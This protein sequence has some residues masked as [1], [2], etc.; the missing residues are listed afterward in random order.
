MDNSPG[1]DH[2]YRLGWAALELAP[3]IDPEGKLTGNSHVARRGSGSARVCVW[4]SGQVATLVAGE[5][6]EWTLGHHG[7]CGDE[8][9]LV[10]IA[11]N[12]GRDSGSLRTV[13]PPQAAE[14]CPILGRFCH[15]E[16]KCF[17]SF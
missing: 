10:Q 9:K 1:S 8:A 5:S 2:G 6:L 16:Q 12:R 14:V 15:N 17:P 3:R 11:G 4:S 7:E 13:S